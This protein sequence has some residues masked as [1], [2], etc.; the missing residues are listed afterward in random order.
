VTRAL[1]LG[2]AGH[3]D[4]GKTT[5][6]RALTGVDTDRLAEEKERG[7]TIDLGFAELVEGDIRFGVVDVPGHEGFVRNMLAGATGMDAALLVVAADEGVMPQTSEHV[8]ILDLLGVRR[9]VVALTRSDIAD[10]EWA[11]LV[12]EEVR[13]LLSDTG[14]PD[15]PILRTAVPAEGEPSGLAELRDALVTMAGG[16][17]E[18]RRASDLLHLPIDR[19]FTVKGTGTVVTGTLLSGTLRAGAAV[20]IGPEGIRARVRGLQVHGRE[21]EEATPG[22]RVAVALTGAGID[23]EALSR[24]QAIVPERGWAPS[25]MLTSRVRVLPDTGWQLADGQR[26]RVHLGTAEVMARCAVLGSE[27][28]DPDT[29]SLLAAGEEGWVQLRLEAP[30]TARVGMPFVVRAWSPVTTIAGGVV[31]E[32]HPARRRGRAPIALLERRISP[33]PATRVEAALEVAGPGGLAEEEL[34]VRTGLTPEVAARARDAVIA[35]GAIAGDD[36]R[37]FAP[38]VAAEVGRQMQQ[39]VDRSH[40]DAP[41]MAGIEVV[42]L[43]EGLPRSAHAGLADAVL[44]HLADVG[45]LEVTRGLVRRAGFEPS[46]SAEQTELRE[47]IADHYAA[48]GLEPPRLADLPERFTADP[49]FHALL[50]ALEAEG[51]LVP[52]DEE[53]RIDA[54]ALT[55]AIDAVKRELGGREG[56]GPS[57]FREW[58]PVS[59]RWLLP[60]L[61]YMDRAG[62]TE[63]NGSD[64][65]VPLG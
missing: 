29:S 63:F 22:A 43:R 20:S 34:A 38:S 56:L 7:I 65:S 17:E 42:R 8:A 33:D 41:W 47:Q 3:I 10:P 59:R 45:E 28:P 44:G 60:I 19:V 21:V 1:I 58:V 6:V 16:A 31:A 2:T 9:V 24:G 32:S 39:Q 53:Y 5:L 13:D 25:R 30:I 55:S 12:E 37:L 62:V 48:A 36:G 64:R 4:H 52:L 14:F 18:D 26:V 50:R 46:L 40:A 49:A 27:S 54:A 61:A 35:R 23:T 11:D 15:A 57:D 51:R